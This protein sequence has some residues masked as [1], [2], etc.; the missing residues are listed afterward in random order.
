M[1]SFNYPGSANSQLLLLLLSS[2]LL[3]LAAC[4]GPSSGEGGGEQNDK[5]M[6]TNHLIHENSPYLLQH[7][8]NPVNW[9]PWGDEALEKAK[10]ENKMLIISIGYAACHW[11]HVMEHESF[12]DTTV[13]RIMNEH[14]VAIK[15][16]RE[17]RPDVDDVYMTACHLSSQGSCGWP[18]NAFALPDGRPVWAGT[19]FPKDKWMEILEYFAKEYK[20]NPEKMKEFADQLTQSIQQIDQLPVLEKQ[21]IRRKDLDDVARK[22]MQSID[23]QYGG[24][25]S[26]GNKF[27]MPN[28]YEFLLRYH[29]LSGNAE[30]GKLAFNTLDRMRLGGIY[31]QIGGGFARYSTDPLWHVPHF[32]KMLY[33][34]GQLVSLYAEAYRLSK[35]DKWARVIRETLDFIAREMTS[36]EGGFYSSLDADSEGEEGKFYVWTKAEIDSLIQDEALNKLFCDFYGVTARGNW[37]DGKNVL[38]A[39]EDEEAFAKKNKMS[40]E[41][42]LQHLAKAKKILFEARSQRTPPGLDNKILTSWNALMLQGYIDAYKALG[43]ETYRSAALKNA[44]FLTQNMLQKDGHLLRNYKDGK[45]KIDAFLDD[46]ALLA[47]AFMSLYEITFDEQWLYK[48]KELLEY[49]KEHFSDPNNPLYYYTSNASQSLIARKKETSDNVIPSSNS[50][51]ARDFDR[52][53]QFMY[54]PEFA[55][56][57]HAMLQVMWPQIKDSGQ[58][59]F[60]S[61]WLQAALEHAWQPY[62]VA[63]LGPQ[64]PEMALELQRDFLPSAVVLAGTDEGSLEMLKD[65]L[66][67]GANMIYVCQDGVCKLPVSE[68]EKAL[69]LMSY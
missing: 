23:P 38:L 44:E 26:N 61:N 3:G 27:P 25:K 62:E 51:L 11:C 69:G 53:H 10:K 36:P 5:H 37:E 35:D 22:F 14:F 33:D 8:H 43:D 40:T 4:H 17:E 54:L 24:R 29:A 56:E 1:K 65:R 41:E 63:I 32:E 13:A 2:I 34:N 59:T 49:A 52:I 7:A 48:A 31:D 15:V 66:V 28:N 45:A 60:F 20:E 46:Y 12:E 64:A 18:L 21:D 6:Y 58:P 57:A 9:Y 68:L 30:A 19:Y 47:Q 39:R 50:V 16:D 55:T 67:D 42:L